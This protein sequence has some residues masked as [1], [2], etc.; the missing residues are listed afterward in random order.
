MTEA[1]LE[2]GIDHFGGSVAAFDRWADGLLESLRGNPVA[3]RLFTTA[4]HLGD[5]SLIWHILGLARGLTTDERANQAFVLAAF[6]G[7]ESLVVNQ[8]VKRVFRRTR[9]T[10]AGDDRYIIRRPSTSS[11]PSGHASA[12]FAAAS[13]LTSWD[14]KRSAPLWFSLATVV[15]LSRAYVR[16]HHPSDVVAGAALGLA[17]AAGAKRILRALA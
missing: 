14:G 7:M 6:L 3:D 12:A 11:F 4:S 17:L 10:P 13:M 15:G 5:F 16:I 1:V 2:R 9:P 8:G